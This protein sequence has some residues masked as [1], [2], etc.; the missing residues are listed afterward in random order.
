MDV[1]GCE[2]MKRSKRVKGLI[3]RLLLERTKRQKGG[4]ARE[5]E[6]ERKE[7]TYF[8]LD[9]LLPFNGVISILGCCDFPYI[10]LKLLSMPT[11]CVMYTLYSAKSL[12][13]P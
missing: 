9:N 10:Y 5:R 1:L 7:E 6:R 13:I 4:G 2:M 12:S 3:S 8:F 11:F